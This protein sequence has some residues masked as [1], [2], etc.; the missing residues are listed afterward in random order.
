MHL[1]FQLSFK[2][3]VNQNIAHWKCVAVYTLRFTFRPNSLTVRSTVCCATVHTRISNHGSCVKTKSRRSFD[4]FFDFRWNKRLSKQWRG[5]WFETQSCP[6]WRHRNER[7]YFYWFTVAAQLKNP[8]Y[9]HIVEL[10]LYDRNKMAAIYQTTF[11]NAFSWMK[12]YKLW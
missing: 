3:N 8:G 2:S 9:F 4:V 7:T 1:F 12:M 10:T 11:S 6:L 5:W